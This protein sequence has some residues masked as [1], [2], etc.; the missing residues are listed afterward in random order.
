MMERN[1]NG[2][3]MHVLVITETNIARVDLEKAEIARFAKANYSCRQGR[4]VQGGGGGGVLIYE[5]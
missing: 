5:K 1:A 3:E 2:N 4:N